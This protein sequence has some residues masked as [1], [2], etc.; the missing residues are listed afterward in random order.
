MDKR[1]GRPGH[2]LCE[3]ANFF[4]AKRPTSRDFEVYTVHL[5]SRPSLTVDL[6]KGCMGESDE[7]WNWTGESSGTDRSDDHL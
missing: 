3:K 5:C 4:F 2:I 7:V 6:D 1:H